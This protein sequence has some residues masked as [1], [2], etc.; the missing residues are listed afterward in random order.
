MF[1]MTFFNWNAGSDCGSGGDNPAPS[2]SSK[3]WVYVLVTYV[4]ALINLLLLVL[5]SVSSAEQAEVT[6]G[7]LPCL[8]QSCTDFQ[9]R[10]R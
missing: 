1:S 8:M 2:V 10:E 3:I 6:T 9:R 7:S 4:S 5:Y